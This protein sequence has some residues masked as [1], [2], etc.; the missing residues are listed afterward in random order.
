MINYSVGGWGNRSEVLRVRN[1]TTHLWTLAL[2][3]ETKCTKE[4]IFKNGAGI[5]G[6]HYGENENSPIFAILHKT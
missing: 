4:S 2:G 5:T 6:N 3:K 1:T